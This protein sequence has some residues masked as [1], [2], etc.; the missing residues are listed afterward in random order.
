MQLLTGGPPVQLTYFDSEPSSV[1][2]HAWSR[3]GKK[4][5]ITRSRLND[6]D[7]VMFQGLR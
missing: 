4:L 6:T 2:A 5:A 3:D 1:T 7:V